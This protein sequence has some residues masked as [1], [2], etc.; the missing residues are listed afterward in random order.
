MGAYEEF[1]EYIDGK[2]DCCE[3]FVSRGPPCLCLK[4]VA[5][6]LEFFFQCAQ[7]CVRC[8]DNCSEDDTETVVQCM[9]ALPV[10][11]FGLL[12]LVGALELCC[13][14]RKELPANDYHVQLCSCS[15]NLCLAEWTTECKRGCCL[16]FT[17]EGGWRRRY[18]RDNCRQIGI[19]LWFPCMASTIFCCGRC[20]GDS[21]P[22]VRHPTYPAKPPPMPS[23]PREAPVLAHGI[24]VVQQMTRPPS[25]KK[26]LPF[27]VGSKYAFIVGVAN[28]KYGD[29]LHYTR[30]D[31]RDMADVLS[32]IGFNIQIELDPDKELFFLSL[33]R[34]LMKLQPGDI[35][36]F[37]FSGH[38]SE[39]ESAVSLCLADNTRVSQCTVQ[40]AIRER[41]AITV[42][43]LDCCRVVRTGSAFKWDMPSSTQGGTKSGNGAVNCFIIVGHA[44]SAGNK[45]SGSR[46]NRQNGLFTRYLLREI[47]E[48]MPLTRILS[49]VSAKMHKEHQQ[50]PWVETWTG[51][52]GAENISLVAPC[53]VRSSM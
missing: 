23:A 46:S 29:N 37:Y 49:I 39:R 45:A 40:D 24:P 14:A 2:G 53:R 20:D 10:F 43:L 25:K 22:V 47:S 27:K 19:C 17:K 38:G 36:V 1:N 9:C 26:S 18:E 35:A 32:K 31:A 52:E 4:Y 6:N 41:A 48:D 5:W 44:T 30:K 51:I 12:P 33:E 28:Y 21:R 3:D 42:L 8:D 11:W 13:E 7:V 50:Q 15:R 34:F 16:L